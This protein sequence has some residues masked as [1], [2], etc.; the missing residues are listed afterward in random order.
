MSYIELYTKI[1]AID[2]WKARW[3]SNKTLK[4][5]VS[6]NSCNPNRTQST[7]ASAT[8]L[9]INSPHGSGLLDLFCTGKFLIPTCWWLLV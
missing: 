9:Q 3:K 5:C 2:A 6:T 1:E 7:K 8:G 4:R